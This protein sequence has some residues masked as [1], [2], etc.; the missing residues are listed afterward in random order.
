MKPTLEQIEAAVCERFKIRPETI[1]T[2]CKRR[3]IVRP[4][5]IAMY[6]ARTLSGIPYDKIGHY[7]DRDHTT[8]LVGIRRIALL[9]ETKPKVAG[10]LN[11]LEAVLAPVHVS[12]APLEPSGNGVDGMSPKTMEAA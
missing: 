2:R 10:Y 1:H 12:A 4:R 5:Q 6:L 9:R 8:A 3:P 7:F 11:E